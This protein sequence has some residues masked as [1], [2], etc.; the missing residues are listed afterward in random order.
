MEETSSNRQEKEKV[1]PLTVTGYNKHKAG[2]DLFD[3]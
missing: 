3:Q 1:K 2:V